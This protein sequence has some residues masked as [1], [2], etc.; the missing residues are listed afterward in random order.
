[1]TDNQPIISQLTEVINLLRSIYI[2]D[3]VGNEHP[4]KGPDAAVNIHNA[5]RE[6]QDAREMLK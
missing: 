5:L 3:I 1:M 4:D 6:L 2:C